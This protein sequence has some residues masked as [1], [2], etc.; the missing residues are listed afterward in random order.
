MAILNMN[1]LYVTVHHFTKF[2][3]N[4]WVRV[5]VFLGMDRQRVGRTDR[6]M[7]ARNDNNT[8]RQG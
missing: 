8:C 3:A 7:D 4:S 6:Q 2:E 1:L 5:V